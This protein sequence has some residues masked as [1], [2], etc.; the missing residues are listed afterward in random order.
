MAAPSRTGLPFPTAGKSLGYLKQ[1]D[2]LVILSSASF[3]QSNGN[4]GVTFD[5]IYTAENIGPYKP[6]PR[7]F[8]YML[9]QLERRGISKSDILHTAESLFHD[10]AP[11][12]QYGLANCW[13]YRRHDQEGFGAT[14]NPSDFRF[15]SM[16]NLVKVH[17]AEAS[18]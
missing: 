11:A 13:I 7:N 16:A 12:M 3:S 8:D 10:H 9:A 1:H 2:K 15:N 4:L 18:G 14:M 17:Q 6:S 5:A